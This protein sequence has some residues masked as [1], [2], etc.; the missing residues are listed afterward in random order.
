MRVK[1]SFRQS[2]LNSQKLNK[3]CKHKPCKHRR[4]TSTSPPPSKCNRPSGPPPSARTTSN[5]STKR[6]ID[7]TSW[8]KRHAAST[9]NR[10]PP[11]RSHLKGSCLGV[12]IRAPNML[13]RTTTSVSRLSASRPWW[14][15]C[16]RPL[17]IWVFQ[18]K[19]IT[20]LC[21]HLEAMGNHQFH[22]ALYLTILRRRVSL[23]TTTTITRLWGTSITLLRMSSKRKRWTHQ[24]LHWQLKWPPY[25]TLQIKV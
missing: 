2:S 1:L 4:A 16:T 3:P 13:T 19:A 18:N 23:S 14:M 15:G 12:T 6:P 10:P 11:S 24:M 8:L 21:L 7:V 22:L 25:S 20:R 17:S 5:A 9:R